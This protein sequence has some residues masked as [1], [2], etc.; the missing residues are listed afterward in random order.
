MA[1]ASSCNDKML[2]LDKD[3]NVP[4]KESRI[5]SDYGVKQSNS[6]HWLRVVNE[7][8]TGPMLLEDPFSREKVMINRPS[9]WI[10]LVALAY[11]HVN[12]LPDSD[13]SIASTMN[14]SLSASSMPA[15][16]V[17]LVSSGYMK[18]LPMSREPGS[19]PTPLARPRY[20]RASQP[21]LG[22][23]AAQTPFGKP[24][25]PKQQSNPAMKRITP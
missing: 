19:L 25:W 6:D 16:Q 5:T 24:R 11:R 20:L 17:P 7:D 23:K 10:P 2:L 22:A 21:S 14:A 1:A 12:A 13:R 3:T 18:V 9:S 8:Q 4:G 15:E